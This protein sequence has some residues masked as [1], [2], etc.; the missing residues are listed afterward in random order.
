[1]CCHFV[2]EA[3]VPNFGRYV[4]AIRNL[5]ASEL[6]VCELIGSTQFG[7]LRLNKP[8]NLK[9]KT[10][11][12]KA[13]KCLERFLIKNFRNKENDLCA[14]N[15]NSIENLSEQLSSIRT[16]DTPEENNSFLQI[17]VPSKPKLLSKEELHIRTFR[18]LG[19][20]HLL[21]EDYAKALSAYQVYMKLNEDHYK[22]IPFMY[23]LALVYFHYNEH[24]WLHIKNN[25]EHIMCGPVPASSILFP[26]SEAN[27]TS[28]QL[29]AKCGIPSLFTT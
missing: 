2:F 23:G 28:Q 9:K 4:D 10:L 29:Q 19:H 20:F 3:R 16:D 8:D 12:L 6:H 26:C 14:S 24:F 21:L 17:F 15:K 25:K 5:G 27:I 18:K 1:M 11:V 13:V 7:F 22:D